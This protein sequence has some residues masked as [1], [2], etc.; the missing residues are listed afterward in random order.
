MLR[1]EQWI[2]FV[3][4]HNVDQV[5]ECQ[6]TYQEL[7]IANSLDWKMTNP[8]KASCET[9]KMSGVEEGGVQEAEPPSCDLKGAQLPQLCKVF[10]K[11]ERIRIII[12]L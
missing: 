2:F 12:P 9:R 6:F 5:S 3:V 7:T 4:T 10:W 1:V 11:L 8:E